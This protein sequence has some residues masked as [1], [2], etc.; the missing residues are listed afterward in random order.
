MLLTDG[1]SNG[2]NPEGPANQLRNLG[3]SIFSIGVGSFV[4]V[5]ELNGIASDPDDVH[6]LRPSSFDQLA[7]FV[8]TVSSVTCSGRF[9]GRKAEILQ[10]EFGERFKYVYG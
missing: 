9:P 10:T 6:V 5:S 2:I 3:V 7:H 1:I 4:S 8:N